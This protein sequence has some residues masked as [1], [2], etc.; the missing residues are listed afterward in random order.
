[1]EKCTWGICARDGLQRVQACSPLWKAALDPAGLQARPDLGRDC[2]IC[3]VNTPA[4]GASLVS[5][6]VSANTFYF[7]ALGRLRLRLSPRNF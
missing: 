5:P 2:E 7:F 4:H 1:M 6:S 3:R